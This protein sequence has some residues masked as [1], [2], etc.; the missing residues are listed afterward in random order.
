MRLLTEKAINNLAQ[1][2]DAM[3]NRGYQLYVE[4]HSSTYG[5]L[6]V[7]IFYLKAFNFQNPLTQVKKLHFVLLSFSKTLEN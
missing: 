7:R 3:V 1:L 2:E 5:L 6:E 4:R